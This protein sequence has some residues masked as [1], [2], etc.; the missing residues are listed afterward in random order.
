MPMSFSVWGIPIFLAQRQNPFEEPI[1]AALDAE[2]GGGALDVFFDLL[3]VGF[4][5]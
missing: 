4:C 5:T 1:E 2:I 3:A